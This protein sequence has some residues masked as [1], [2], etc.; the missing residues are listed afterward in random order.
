VQPQDALANASFADYQR[1]QAGLSVGAGLQLPAG[2]GV[3]VRAYSGLTRVKEQ[4]PGLYAYGGGIR[5]RLVQASL[6][7]QFPAKP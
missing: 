4:A 6:S 2:F 5:S 1:V 7:Y 3:E